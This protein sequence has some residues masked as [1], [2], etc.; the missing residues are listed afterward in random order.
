MGSLDE[1]IAEFTSCLAG[2]DEIAAKINRISDRRIREN[3]ADHFYYNGELPP[4]GFG[5]A[6][7][8]AFVGAAERYLARSV[9]LEMPD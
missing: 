1:G 5:D 2:G 3:E 9:R 8:E 6:E 4:L 7:V